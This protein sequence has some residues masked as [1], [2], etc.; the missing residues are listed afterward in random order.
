MGGEVEDEDE[1]EEGEVPSGFDSERIED[2]R[3]CRK[4]RPVVDV[5]MSGVL[6]D[7]AAEIEIKE[8]PD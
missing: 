6:E 1:D 2:A 5:I 7:G 3:N 4:Q 8:S